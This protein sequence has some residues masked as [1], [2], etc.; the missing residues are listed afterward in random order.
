MHFGMIE[1]VTSVNT[2]MATP[3]SVGIVARLRPEGLGIRIPSPTRGMGFSLL[4]SVQTW[5]GPPRLYSIRT[6][7]PVTGSE[8]V[9]ARVTTHFH[10][11]PN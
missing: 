8:A 11:G 2:Y 7:R 4:R 10:L 6:G 1:T 3:S 9:R 5:L